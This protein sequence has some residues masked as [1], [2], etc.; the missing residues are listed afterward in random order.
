M[1]AV[2]FLP[3]APDSEEWQWQQETVIGGEEEA[4]LVNEKSSEMKLNERSGLSATAVGSK[5]YLIGG[6]E[7]ATG[8]CFND[9][10]IYDT[11]TK[12][13]CV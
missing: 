5:I 10:L 11:T 3:V 2:R 4:Q 8:A 13:W 1:L 12:M 6:Q 9:V 7:P